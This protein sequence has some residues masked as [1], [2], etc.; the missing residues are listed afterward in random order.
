MNPDMMGAD[1]EDPFG[2]LQD[3]MVEALQP[4]IQS[5]QQLVQAMA[6]M[7]A[8]TM[9]MAKQNQALLH[10]VTRALSAPKQIIRDNKGQIAGVQ[11]AQVN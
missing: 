8:E 6:Q 5:M 1:G 3:P 7:H 11:T 9:Q 10:S 2:D 4:L